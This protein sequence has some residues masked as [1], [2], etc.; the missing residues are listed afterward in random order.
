MKNKTTSKL[1]VF[2]IV[3]ITLWV[4]YSIIHSML[5]WFI[6][7]NL[8]AIYII[9][10][11]K[12]F[13]K[14]DIAV[15]VVFGALCMPSNFIAGLS[16]VLPYIA[17]MMIFKNSKNRIYLFKTGKRNDIIITTLLILVVGGILGEINVLFS[18]KSLPVNFLINMEWFF[19]AMLRSLK[20]SASEVK[21]L[22]SLL[23]SFKDYLK[24]AYPDEFGIHYLDDLNELRDR[25]QGPTKEEHA[26]NL[27]QLG[28]IRKFLKDNPKFRKHRYV[29]EVY[30]QLGILKNDLQYCTLKYLDKSG[31][32]WFF[33]KP[34][35]DKILLNDFMK[36]LIKEY[37]DNQETAYMENNRTV[38]YY[39]RQIS[40][41]LRDQGYFPYDNNLVLDDIK[42][43]RKHFFMTCP[44]CGETFESFADNWVLAKA[45]TDSNYHLVCKV[46]K[47]EPQYDNKCN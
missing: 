28:C 24:T 38:N 12:I 20:W 46:C 11:Y 34:D 2:L 30:F 22:I 16:T 10:K 21:N 13:D 36:Q 43:T 19:D 27:S 33:K 29:F 1:I 8:I 39:L 18:I 17:A 25:Y 45:E 40:E 14:K 5:I 3:L 42:K 26:L 37:Q 32:K 4:V 23:N 15:G 7:I 44:N 47:G 31:E 9:L 6:A 35:G 41:E